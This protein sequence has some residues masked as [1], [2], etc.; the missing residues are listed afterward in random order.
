MIGSVI[1]KY[2]VLQK[3]GEGATATVY[4]GRHLSIGKDVAIKVLHPHLSASSRYRERFHREAR[5]VGR[6]S[7]DNIVS[8]LDYSGQ[9]NE[10]CYI[11][12][13][14]VDGV[15]LLQLIEEHG[16][17]PSEILV[18]IGLE[19]A[20][21]LA[22]AHEHGIIHR[23]I[24]PEN[25][26]V[27]RDGV[28]KLMDFGVARVLDEGQI[29]LDGSLLGSPAYMSP[30]QAV[31]E[32]LD[33]RSDLFSLGTVLFHA[34][35][36][37]VPFA[38][39]NASIILRN[40]IDGQRAEVLE[41]NPQAAPALAAVIDKLLQTRVEDR[42]AAAAE[43]ETALAAVLVESGLRLDHPRINLRA[44]LVN[45][46]DVEAALATHL[47]T[48]LLARGKERLARGDTMGALQLFNR[49][50]AVDE[51][52]EEVLTL[53]Q[54]LHAAPTQR[55]RVG[56]LGIVAA[57]ALLL[58]GL[59]AWAWYPRSAPAEA[60]PAP[61]PSAELVSADP[62]TS[63][64]PAT[65]APPSPEIAATDPQQP[66]SPPTTSHLPGSRII[67]GSRPPP[68]SPATAALV[69]APDPSTPGTVVIDASQFYTPVEVWVDGKRKGKFR[70]GPAKEWVGTGDNP[71]EVSPGEHELRVKNDAMEDWSVRF[72]V[73]AGERQQVKP[74]LRPL[75][76]QILVNPAM[77]G[78]CLLTVG[79]TPYGPLSGTR[80]TFVKP[81]DP[82]AQVIFDCGDR[83]RFPFPVPATQAG[84][85][86]IVPVE[87]PAALKS[88]LGATP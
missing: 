24:K 68:P 87:L 25:V 77:P 1:D 21:A 27:R 70:D 18:A 73:A 83:G 67:T 22:F 29:T 34:V 17:I 85:L 36:G 40:I 82:D 53:I 61:K 20:S 16:R 19:L 81:T 12:T 75:S 84:K 78:D 6:L 66:A 69:A 54:S 72:T 10:E 30:Q 11:V 3:L 76:A 37:H 9:N 57:A 60:P 47:L 33:G 49:L 26:M 32:K 79:T 31:D 7:H 46:K 44:W 45:P 56:V 13:E 55:T 5:A 4:R 38:G 80:R 52:H 86:T 2:E 71:I 8:I 51:E 50:L 28:V 88:A 64:N 39:S 35:T 41:L 48:D 15:T 42:Y 59:G 63:A 23:D 74:E 62:P 43:V 14:L 65:V 58:A